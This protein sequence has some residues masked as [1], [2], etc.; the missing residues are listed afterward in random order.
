MTFV[1]KNSHYI[2]KLFTLL[3]TTLGYAM[4]LRYEQSYHASRR[5]LNFNSY[6]K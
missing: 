4:Y 2:G 5:F 3:T 1:H 6:P